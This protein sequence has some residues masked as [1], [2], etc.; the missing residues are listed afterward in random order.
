MGQQPQQQRLQYQTV[1]KI[2]I[3][4]VV[5]AIRQLT[6]VTHS[7]NTPGLVLQL[8]WIIFLPSNM[9]SKDVTR[10]QDAILSSTVVVMV[11]LITFM[12]EQQNL[13]RLPV[14]VHGTRTN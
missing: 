12:K 11:E 5:H 2:P 7:R 6:S 13:I 10:N 9:Q 1:D 3:A 4:Q 14:L 8:I